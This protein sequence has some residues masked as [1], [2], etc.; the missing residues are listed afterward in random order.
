LCE[1]YVYR[2]G[3][4]TLANPRELMIRVS[5]GATVVPLLFHTDDL[6]AER[7]FATVRGVLAATV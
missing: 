5:A 6:P 1:A 3:P 7:V 4:G 2:V